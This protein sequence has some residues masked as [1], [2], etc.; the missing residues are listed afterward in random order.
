MDRLDLEKN[1]LDL[2]YQRNLQLLNAVLIS[3]IGAFFAYF[4]ALILNPERLLPYTLAMILV[5]IITYVF[6]RKI[7]E[8]LKVI[9]YKLRL[10]Y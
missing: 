2:A 10:L 9:S 5:G 3:G 1:C 4:G 7:D 6:Y 8:R